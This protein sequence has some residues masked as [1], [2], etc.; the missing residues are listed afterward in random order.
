[1]ADLGRAYRDGQ[2]IGQN[3]AEAS[4][5][6]EQAARQG[7]PGAAAALGRMYLDGDGVSRDPAKG[8]E[9]LKMAVAREATPA[10]EQTLAS[11]C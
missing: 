4:R 3:N 6:L 1:M 5:W 10:R 8:A 11:C 9:L 2:G 7:H